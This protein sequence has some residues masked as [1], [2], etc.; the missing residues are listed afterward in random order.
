MLDHDDALTDLMREHLAAVV[1]A[2]QSLQGVAEKLQQQDGPALWRHA[3]LQPGIEQLRYALNG[4]EHLYAYRDA[5][6]YMQSTQ[7]IADAI[8]MRNEKGG[9]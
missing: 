8:R 5:W 2:A 4:L 3:S 1:S 6:K 9:D 7:A